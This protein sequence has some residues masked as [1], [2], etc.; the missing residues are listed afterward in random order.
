M[1]HD[2]FAMHWA[3]GAR[4]AL[5][6]AHLLR[7]LN[8]IAQHDRHRSWANALADVLVD[9]HHA[10]TRV[11]QHGDTV[12]AGPELDRIDE[13]YPQAIR[14]ALN[15]V[16]DFADSPAERTATNLAAAMYDYRHET[17]VFTRNLA[18]PFDNN[19]AGRD[20]RMTKIHQRTSGG[21]RSIVGAQHFTTIRSY[22]ETAL[23][24]GHDTSLSSS[25][26]TVP[27]LDNPP[28]E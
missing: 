23:K 1:V 8:G 20:L 24:H 14:A 27:D 19:Q 25:V 18:V 15:T 11:R 10:C 16:D 3:Y 5:C 17:L 12:L 7:D 6:G 28:P 9:T 21:W 22:I 2:R 4:H 26:S 13:R